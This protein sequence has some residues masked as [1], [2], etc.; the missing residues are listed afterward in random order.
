MRVSPQRCRNKVIHIACAPSSSTG[1]GPHARSLPGAPFREEKTPD[2]RAPV[3]ME[4]ATVTSPLASTSA[5]AGRRQGRPPWINAFTSSTTGHTFWPSFPVGGGAP[6]V[7]RC[8]SQHALRSPARVSG[9][10][11]G[12]WPISPD[13]VAGG[14]AL[15]E[16]ACRKRR[17]GHSRLEARW[18]Q[19]CYRSP[20]AAPGRRVGPAG[21][22]QLRTVR[23]R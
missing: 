20:G 21:G 13:A 23:C 8:C 17:C 12:R 6:C 7:D 14:L 5:A 4:T 1:V 11:H 2:K 10:P 16:A 22:Q 9:C 18:A 19:L 3:D 15:V